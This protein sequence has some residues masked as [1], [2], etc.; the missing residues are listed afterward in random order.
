MTGY[1]PDMDPGLRSL[2]EGVERQDPGAL[3]EY[4]QAVDNGEITEPG[5]DD[6]W[7]LAAE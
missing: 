7:P 3:A 1:H 6:P 4:G 5:P 2:L